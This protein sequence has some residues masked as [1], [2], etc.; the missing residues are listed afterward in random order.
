MTDNVMIA[1]GYQTREENGTGRLHKINALPVDPDRQE[2]ISS[3]SEPCGRQ[4]WKWLESNYLKS[5]PE[6]AQVVLVAFQAERLL[7]LLLYELFP[8][9][10]YDLRP[11]LDG[12]VFPLEVTTLLRLTESGAAYLVSQFRQL[13]PAS[14]GSSAL[15]LELQKEFDESLKAWEGP[16]KSAAADAWL[17]FF[18]LLRYGMHGSLR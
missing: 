3:D 18:V 13:R 2:F 6:G 16:G 9:L 1:V 14:G 17:C 12:S 11:I 8:C 7:R 4:F 5:K 15:L 10:D